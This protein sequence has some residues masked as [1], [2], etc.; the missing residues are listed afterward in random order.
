MGRGI[1]P[2]PIRIDCAAT[3][4]TRQVPVTIWSGGADVSWEITPAQARSLPDALHRAVRARHG[5]SL[6]LP[7]FGRARI[8][9]SRAERTVRAVGLIIVG[10]VV[11]ASGM[12]FLA[13]QPSPVIEANIAPQPPSS[14]SALAIPDVA[15]PGAEPSAVDARPPAVGAGGPT[16]EPADTQGL[17][18]TFGLRMR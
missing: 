6:T 3:T 10:F 17:M 16:D 13:G 9:R 4:S 2:G 12:S 11:A 7:P 8:W 15:A 5:L 18:E 1:E 14:P